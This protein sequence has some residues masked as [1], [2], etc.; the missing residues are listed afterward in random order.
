LIRIAVEPFLSQRWKA[1]KPAGPQVH[2]PSCESSF[3][4]HVRTSAQLGEALKEMGKHPTDEEVRGLV[5]Q[6]D[7][8]NSGTIEFDEFCAIMGRKASS[9]DIEVLL[10][11]FKVFDKDGSGFLEPAELHAIFASLGTAT[12]RPPSEEMIDSMI[13]EADIDGD[14]KINR[15][16]FVKLMIEKKVL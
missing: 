12:F 8:D 1:V 15:D 10:E 11:A 6:V 14:G 16:E 7:R 2:P 9:A 13:K 3:L 5:R 4:P